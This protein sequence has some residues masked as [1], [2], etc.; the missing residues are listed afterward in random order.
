MA[1]SDRVNVQAEAINKVCARNLHQSLWLPETAAHGR[2]RVTY[3]TTCNFGDESL[4]VVLFVG[5]MFG[6]RYH[7]LEIETLAVETGVRV[8]CADRPGMGGSTPCPLEQRVQVWI[9]TVPALMAALGVSHVSLLTHSAGAVYLLNTMYHHRDLLDPQNPYVA[10]IAP[11]VDYLHSQTTIGVL[12]SKLPNNLIS[13]WSSVFKFINLRIAPAFNWSGDVFSSA[14][15]LLN[16]EPADSSDTTTD[17]E[18]YGV[19]EP[20][21]RELLSYRTKVWMAEDSSAANDEVLLCLKKGEGP[22]WGVCEDYGRFVVDF[23]EKEAGR[24][25]TGVGRE[26]DGGD[27]GGRL[28]LRTFYAESDVMIGSEGQKYFDECWRQACVEGVVDFAAKELPKT[29]HESV[30]V[31]FKKGALREVFEEKQAIALRQ[32]HG[33]VDPGSIFL[34]VPSI[35]LVCVG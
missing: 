32:P 27:D 2:L 19:S 13:H 31:D 5:P 23:C 7:I 22:V 6:N 1:K 16:P 11:W 20:V 12:T 25:G 14:S 33:L 24:R 30:L 4:P 9:E 15:E 8:I 34:P 18:R 26:S 29:D 28:R 10:I 17:A 3:A 21:A 35:L